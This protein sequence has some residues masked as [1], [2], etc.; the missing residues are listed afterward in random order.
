VPLMDSPRLGTG[1]EQTARA[2]VD[3]A[4]GRSQQ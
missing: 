3:A 4:F 1:S 2:L